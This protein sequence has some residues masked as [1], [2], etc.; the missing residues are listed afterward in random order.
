MENN[1][2]NEQ[3]CTL[4]KLKEEI[5]KKQ[6]KLNRIILEGKNKDQILRFSQELDIL[7]TEYLSINFYKK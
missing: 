4:N 7:I 2:N 6:E 1:N 5:R 3:Q